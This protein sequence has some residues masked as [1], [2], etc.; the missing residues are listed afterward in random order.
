MELLLALLALCV[1]VLFVRGSPPPPSDNVKCPGCGNVV[2]RQ[3]PNCRTNLG[4]APNLDCPACKLPAATVPCPRCKIDI[5][6]VPPL[7]A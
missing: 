7:P 6:K 1:P 5:K 4:R 2:M 3:C